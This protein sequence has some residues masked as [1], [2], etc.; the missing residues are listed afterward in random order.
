MTMIEGNGLAEGVSGESNTVLSMVLYA[1][2]RAI[3]TPEIKPRG[4]EKGWREA[5]AKKR[6][7]ALGI[8]WMMDMVYSHSRSLSHKM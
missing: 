1:S 4:E 7:E 5:E 3:L 2:D 6:F 8:N